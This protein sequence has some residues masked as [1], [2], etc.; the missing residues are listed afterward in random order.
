MPGGPLDE[1]I[2]ERWSDMPRSE[3]NA[4]IERIAEVCR[5]I[6][7]ANFDWPDLVTYHLY[8]ADDAI[9]VLDPARLKKGKLDLSALY[10]STEE[11]TVSQADRLRFWRHYAGKKPPQKLRKIG[12]RGRFRPYRWAKQRVKIKACP[13]W[14]NFVNAID[15]PFHSADELAD[16][17]ELNIKRELADR[18]NATL[19]NL[20]IKIV[21]DPDEA[22]REWQ[23]HRILMASGFR[24]PQPAVGGVTSDGRGLFSTVRLEGQYPMDDVWATLDR[25][26]AVNAVADIARRLHVSGLVHRDLY[27]CHF[28]VAK[29]GPEFTL[30][31]LARV[32]KSQSRRRRIKDLA[33]LVHSSRG[34][35]SRTDLMRGLKRYGGDK[36]LAKSV[37]RKAR[38]MAKHVPRNVQDGTHVAHRPETG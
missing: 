6:R 27:L 36:R 30:L 34:L 26:V 22:K 12:H 23:N 5:R 19:D 15:A 28:F 3:R 31:D 17:P 33:A 10:W 8:V 1:L 18:T 35:C 7:D 37:L 4:L 9:R 24:V 13:P 2:A 11:P 20:V 38:R 21:A 16:H 32:T 25:R 14:A 29:G